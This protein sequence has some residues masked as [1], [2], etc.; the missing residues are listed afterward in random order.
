LIKWRQ[1]I[2]SFHGKTPKERYGF[3]KPERVSERI[4]ASHS[5]GSTQPDH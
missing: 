4:V 3:G 1:T 5:A 2:A